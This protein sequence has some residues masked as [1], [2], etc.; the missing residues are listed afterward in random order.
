MEICALGYIFGPGLIILFVALYVAFGDR[1]W[2]PGNRESHL[3]PSIKTQ[4]MARFWKEEQNRNIREK[5]YSELLRR[6]NYIPPWL[7]NERETIYAMLN[8]VREG[9]WS[10]QTFIKNMKIQG[11]PVMEKPLSEEQ[12]VHKVIANTEKISDMQG[13]I[14]RYPYLR[15]LNFT[16]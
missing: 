6:I 3:P 15:A 1:P 12:S 5:K 9:K 13:R 10:E 4:P 7:D 14:Q 2:W 8:N 11:Y 16:E